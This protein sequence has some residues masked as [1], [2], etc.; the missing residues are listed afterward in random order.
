LVGQPCTSGVVAED[1][2]RAVS[3]LAAENLGATA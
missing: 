2:V 3:V 1:V